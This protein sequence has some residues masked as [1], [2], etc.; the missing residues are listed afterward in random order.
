MPYRLA[1]VYSSSAE[2]E[3]PLVAASE[4]CA[5]LFERSLPELLKRSPEQLF[6]GEADRRSRRVW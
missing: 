2:G 5:A 1:Q 6:G 3:H 4:N